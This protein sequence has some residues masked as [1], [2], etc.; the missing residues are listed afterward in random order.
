[1]GVST[2]VM[3]LSEKFYVDSG[4]GLL[5]ATGKLYTNDVKIYVQ[6]M[7]TADFHLHLGSVGLDSDW[8]EVPGNAGTVSIHNLTFHG[9]LHRLFQYLLESGCIEEMS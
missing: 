7:R 5:E 6:P 1:M 8:F 2:F 9:P 3:L 4:S